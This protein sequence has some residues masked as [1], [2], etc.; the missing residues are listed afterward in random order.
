MANIFRLLRRESPER[1]E[2]PEASA[3]VAGESRRA[4]ENAT[5]RQASDSE[6]GRQ[7]AENETRRLA[8]EIEAGRQAAENETR[9]L[10]SEI[11]ARRQAADNEALHRTQDDRS[12]E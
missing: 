12:R 5:R 4:A 9:R 6:A 11:E 7:A 3:R 8:S 10:A 2:A 1:V